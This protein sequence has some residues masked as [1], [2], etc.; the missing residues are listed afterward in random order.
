MVYTY[1]KGVHLDQFTMPFKSGTTYKTDTTSFHPRL[2]FFNGDWKYTNTPQSGSSWTSVG[3]NDASWS[4]STDGAF[5][6]FSAITRYYRNT[7]TISPSANLRAVSI[8]IVSDAAVVIYFDGLKVFDY[9]IDP[10]VLPSPSIPSSNIT[11]TTPASSLKDGTAAARTVFIHKAHITSGSHTVAVEIHQHDTQ[12]TNADAFDAF[13]TYREVEDSALSANLFVDGSVTGS[14][15]YSTTYALTKAFDRS[16]STYYYSTQPN[17][18]LIYTFPNGKY[19]P[20]LH[21]SP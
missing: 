20:L 10:Y 17:A 8:N 18:Y 5:P 4:T 13:L 19:A 14:T 11:P 6:A 21:S 2:L 16:L 12:T 1:Y 9:K 7:F 3:F 15:A